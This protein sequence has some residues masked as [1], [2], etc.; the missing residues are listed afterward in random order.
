MKPLIFLAIFLAYCSQGL[1]QNSSC[2]N[3]DLIDS[4]AICPMIYAPVCGCNGVTYSNECIATHL[5]G[6]L[7]YTDGPCS[8]G[9][10]DMSQFDF[11]LCDQFLGYAWTPNG[12]QAFSGCG[13]TYCN[14]DYQNQFFS[15][16]ADCEAQCGPGSCINP[17]QIEQGFLVDCSPFDTNQVCGCNQITYQNSC[18]AYYVGGV[19]TYALGACDS[20]GCTGVPM[21]VDFGACAMP[22]GFVR[23]ASG[24]ESISGCSYIGSNGYDYSDFFF[25]NESDCD[26]FCGIAVCV[27]SSLIDPSVMC[28]A[29]YDPVCGCNGIT[30]G[31]DCVATNYGGVTSW[32]PGECG[33]LC[34]D[35]SLINLDTI[36]P[37]VIAP[38][39]GCDGNTYENSCFAEIGGITSWTNGPCESNCIDSSLIDLSIDCE[40]VVDP[41]CGCDSITY[42][43]ACV[44]LSMHGVTSYTTGPCLTTG[45]KPEVYT[46]DFTLYPNPASQSIHLMR[47]SDE[48]LQVTVLDMSGRVVLSTTITSRN[49]PIDVSALQSGLYMIRWIDASDLNS[50]A[51][52]LVR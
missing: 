52:F 46:H 30:Y 35:S 8:G 24:C 43:N 41:V 29:I 38:V 10:V 31:N 39:C 2:V 14:V 3:C 1:A 27:D 26:S 47:N 40:A 34:Y 32:T 50:S 49:Q 28:L 20:I 45:V 19:T 23:R 48:A 4:S 51:I 5:G 7:S 25:L 42:Q 37:F 6:V 12:C 22:L 36:C 44:A 11:G 18:D 15:E 17:S 33:V 13:W 9:C 16:P 21:E